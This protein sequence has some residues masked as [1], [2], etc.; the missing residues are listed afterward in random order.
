[1]PTMP[2]NISS[3]RNLSSARRRWRL[4]VGSRVISTPL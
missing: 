3:S 1:L 2:S 4:V